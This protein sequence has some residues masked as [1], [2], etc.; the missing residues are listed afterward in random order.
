MVASATE[1]PATGPS[2]ASVRAMIPDYVVRTLKLW[3]RVFDNV[4]SVA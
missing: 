1:R 2:S 4:M 3:A